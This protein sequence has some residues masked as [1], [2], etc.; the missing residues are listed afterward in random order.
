MVKFLVFVVLAL[1]AGLSP[2]NAQS[3]A[4]LRQKGQ[5]SPRQVQPLNWS[6]FECTPQE[7]R[8]VI[9]G[10]VER[11]R[12]TSAT[13]WNKS[14]ARA[15]K[16]K[17]YLALV[18]NRVLLVLDT[19]V[20]TINDG[21]SELA[22]VRREYGFDNFDREYVTHAGQALEVFGLSVRRAQESRFRAVRMV[23]QGPGVTFTTFT[24]QSR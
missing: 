12:E 13:G 1:A 4:E 7:F 11:D 18:E 21:P 23:K 10:Q 2:V 14:D 22:I 8:V 3:T 5:T 17:V 19:A 20:S 6:K 9:N 16:K 24:C 15:Q